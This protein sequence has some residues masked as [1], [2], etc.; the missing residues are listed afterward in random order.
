LTATASVLI[1]K[2]I[3]SS[4][5]FTKPILASESKRVFDLITA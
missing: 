3:V 1:H 2:R 5:R 4:I